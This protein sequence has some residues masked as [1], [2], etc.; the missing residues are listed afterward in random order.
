MH[1]KYKAALRQAL[2][3]GITRLAE[4]ADIG[5]S[6]ANCIRSALDA[7][8]ALVGA[9]M[10]N[11]EELASKG[12][13]SA[14]TV[15]DSFQ[16]DVRDRAMCN[17]IK[18]GAPEVGLSVVEAV[19]GVF[20][21][22]QAIAVLASGARAPSG[23]RKLNRNIT[24]AIEGQRSWSAGSLIRAPLSA[25]STVRYKPPGAAGPRPTGMRSRAICGLY[26]SLPVNSAYIDGE[27]DLAK[28]I[29]EKNK[30][31]LRNPCDLFTIGPRG[32]NP[33]RAQRLRHLHRSPQHTARARNRA[34]RGARR[35]G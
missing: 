18:S 1:V 27:L 17:A 25:R 34:L 32:H 15:L 11:L 4:A 8:G 22:G 28:A 9:A 21:V 31:A 3:E 26:T 33:P 10:A 30:M 7:Q 14:A 20:P 2:P 35:S 5:P 24:Y 29:A 12:S 13:S 23:N 19:C 6:T 16:P